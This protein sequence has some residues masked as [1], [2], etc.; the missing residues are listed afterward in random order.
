MLKW[1]KRKSINNHRFRGHHVL[2]SILTNSE[3]FLKAL[4]LRKDEN[5]FV[6][7]W[8]CK[9]SYT[10]SL[11]SF[12]CLLIYIAQAS[13]SFATLLHQPPKCCDYIRASATSGPH[14]YCWTKDPGLANRFKGKTARVKCAM[15]LGGQSSHGLWLLNWCNYLHPRG[16][17]RHG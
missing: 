3:I 12:I 1:T 16:D 9:F 5:A 11:Y 2:L 8:V 13:L 7:F 10:F 14:C 15:V 4:G 17:P 6:V